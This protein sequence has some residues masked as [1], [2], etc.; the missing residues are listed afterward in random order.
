M[1]RP[2]YPPGIEAAVTR[3]IRGWVDPR[4]DVD[5]AN[6]EKKIPAPTGNGTPVIQP[7]T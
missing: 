1:P 5:E 2:L 3:W 6:N 7:V 4:A